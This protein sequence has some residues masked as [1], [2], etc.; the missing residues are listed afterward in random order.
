MVKSEHIIGTNFWP[1]HVEEA[2]AGGLGKTM[3]SFHRADFPVERYN[4]L[5]QGIAAG[6]FGEARQG[7]LMQSTVMTSIQ[8]WG[9]S[10]NTS[11][12]TFH[13]KTAQSGYIEDYPSAGL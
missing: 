2:F 12:V 13:N 4:A 8:G 3:V 11:A 6:G 9:A 7:L 1:K 5:K 10:D